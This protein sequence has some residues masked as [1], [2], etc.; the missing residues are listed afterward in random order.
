[1]NEWI[2][3]AAGFALLLAG[4]EFLVRGAVTIARSF[5]MS[6]MLIGLTLVGFGTS[7]PELVAS[8]NAALKDAPGLAIG[9]VVGSNIANIFLII[10]VSALILPM[11]TNR[12]A[13]R[14]D[15]PALLIATA[16]LVGVVLAGAID[17]MT[18][19]AGLALLLGYTLYTWRTD[20]RL[21]DDAAAMHG[22]EADEVEMPGTSLPVAFAITLGG[23]AGVLVGADLLVDA[24]IVIARGFGL[25]EA[26][27]GLT[28]VAIGTSL[29]ELT[30]SVMAAI[31]RHA[32][33]AF[34]NIVGS[35]MFNILGI[36]GVTA[37]VTPLAIPAGI[38]A[39]DVWIAALAAVMLVVFAMTGWRIGRR[40]GAI[41]LAAYAL[42][43]AFQLS[44]E[45]RATLGLPA[46]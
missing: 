6:P 11:A 34:G 20:S 7:T 40:E 3:L 33:V 37:L 9:N 21:L 10:G 42:Y 38:A 4:G 31:R 8:V 45:L 16:L 25:S 22:Q 41:L 5:G 14:R 43:I 19:A 28:L 46:A 32:D 23:M 35:C 24:A 29:P 30:T 44:P 27:I 1:M 17:R 13:F 39:F 18:G 36:L 12:A 2:L 15:G 26:V